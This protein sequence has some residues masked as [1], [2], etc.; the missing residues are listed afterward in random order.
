MAGMGD[1]IMPGF[2]AA[3]PA[4]RGV[5]EDDGMYAFASLVSSASLLCC[6][7]A[8][9]CMFFMTACAL[10]YRGAMGGKQDGPLCEL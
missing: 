1:P 5:A 10:I 4:A 3:L 9:F 7:F 8:V 2:A 6:G